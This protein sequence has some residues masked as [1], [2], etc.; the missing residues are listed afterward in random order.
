MPVPGFAKISPA[1]TPARLTTSVRKGT[2]S[3]G[4]PPPTATTHSPGRTY[5]TP[6]RPLNSADRARFWCTHR[7]TPKLP[8]QALA[9]AAICL[10]GATCGLHTTQLFLHT[11]WEIPPIIYYFSI[12]FLTTPNFGTPKIRSWHSTSAKCCTDNIN[13]SFTVPT[14]PTLGKTPK[15]HAKIS[16][17]S[18]SPLPSFG[19]QTFLT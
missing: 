2:L 15:R 19:G 8:P 7:Y 3:S 11:H 6:D 10:T 14:R 13:A 16:F 9:P 1:S 4:S 5:V 18:F 12:N 17:K